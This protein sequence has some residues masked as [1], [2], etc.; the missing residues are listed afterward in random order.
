MKTLILLL[1][2]ALTWAQLNITTTALDS[3]TWGSAYQDTVIA[4]GGTAPYVFR[5]FNRVLPTG[6]YLRGDGYV[7][8][9]PTDT[10][11]GGKTF[12]VSVTDAAGARDVQE[13]TLGVKD[14]TSEEGGGGYATI[15]LTDSVRDLSVYGGTSKTISANVTSENSIMF[16]VCSIP[17]ASNVMTGATFNSD[18]MTRLDSL[19]QAVGRGEIFYLKNPDTGTHNLVASYTTNDVEN[20]FVVVFTGIDLT[21]SWGTTGRDNTITGELISAEVATTREEDLVLSVLASVTNSDAAE[22]GAGEELIARYVNSSAYGTW[23]VA[24]EAGTGSNVT[25]SWDLTSVGTSSGIIWAI[26]LKSAAE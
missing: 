22:I 17:I 23:G 20:F 25:V 6:T 16:L 4:T 7:L 11:G 1:L 26:P 5:V 2:P 9:L 13:L 15:T 19:R 21:D 12:S 24:K 3:S 18:A 8:G 10:A 14:S